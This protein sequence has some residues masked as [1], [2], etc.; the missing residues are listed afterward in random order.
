[1]KAKTIKLSLRRKINEWLSSIDDENVRKAAQRDAI[2]TGGSIASMLLGEEVNDYDVYFRSKDTVKAVAEYYIRQ[3]LKNPSNRF[4]A[5]GD[6]V[7]VYVV[8]DLNRVKII[9]KSSG[10]ASEDGADDYEYFENLPEDSNDAVAY[11]ENVM[12]AIDEDDEKPKY[13]PVFLS[14]NAITLS[15]RIQIIIRFYGEPDAIHENYDF[16]HCTNYWTSNDGALVLRQDALEALLARDL[17]YIGSKYPLCSIIRT[18]KFIRRN[19][20]I[21][22][23]QYLKMAMQLNE[24]DLTDLDV[25]EDQLTGVDTAYFLEVIKKLRAKDKSHVDTAYLIEIIDRMF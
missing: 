18:R 12:T 23:G 21:T 9:V 3:F 16:V 15:H 6:E 19:W 8:E 1:M 22:A 13:R 24:L 11:V 20:S 7:P 17:R 4:K 25:L 5:S 10:I 2:V 14:A